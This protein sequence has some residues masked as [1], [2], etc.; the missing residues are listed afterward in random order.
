MREHIQAAGIQNP[1]NGILP[2]F[3]VFGTQF[4][5]LWQKLLGGLWAVAIIIAVV[6]LIL[7][8]TAMG[9]SSTGGNPLE[10]KVGRT[11][12][13]WAGISLGGLAA[14]AVIVGAILAF[15]S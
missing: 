10:Y 11:Q 13:L 6:Y 4:T 1:L 2:N 5:E 15:A 8:I 7:G 3:T 12:A 9:K 14:I